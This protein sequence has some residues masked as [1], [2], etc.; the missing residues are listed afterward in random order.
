MIVLDL[1]APPSVN[2]TRIVNWAAQ[3]SLSQW[4]RQAD[5]AVLLCRSKQRAAGQL[6]KSIAGPFE[7][8]VTVGGRM[9]IDNG[10][11]PLI[12]YLRQIEAIEND[13]PRHMRRLVVDWSPDIKG[14]RVTI[15][16]I[17]QA[18]AA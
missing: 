11:K 13:D 5:S 15:R 2:R 3:R 6:I 16:P 14:C 10:L 1:P 18:V 9:D 7:I 8:H 12:D 17:D 4:K